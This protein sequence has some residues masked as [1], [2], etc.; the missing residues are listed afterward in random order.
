[1]KGVFEIDEQDPHPNLARMDLSCMNKALCSIVGSIDHRRYQICCISV[2]NDLQLI[3]TAAVS[4][5]RHVMNTL[6]IIIKNVASSHHSRG[7]VLCQIY[8]VLDMR[9]SIERFGIQGGLH[10]RVI[11]MYTS[12]SSHS[13]NAEGCYADVE[14]LPSLVHISSARYVELSMS[15]N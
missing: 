11:R 12:F 13:T 3:W 14:A 4:L 5:A 8:R 2:V 15:E 9:E 7:R 6:V 1:M 10:G